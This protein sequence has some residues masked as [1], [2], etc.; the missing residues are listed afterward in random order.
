MET[1]II[2]SEVYFIV[3]LVCFMLFPWEYVVIGFSMLVWL[4][5]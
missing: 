5:V 2:L 1:F 3:C 4:G